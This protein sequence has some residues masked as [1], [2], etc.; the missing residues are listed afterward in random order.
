M[1]LCILAP[2]TGSSVKLILM[3]D[4]NETLELFFLLDDPSTIEALEKSI[5]DLQ[6]YYHVFSK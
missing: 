2:L 4:R 6:K 5:V 3:I 1:V